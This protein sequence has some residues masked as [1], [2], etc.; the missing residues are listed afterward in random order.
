M[1]ASHRANTFEYRDADLKETKI[2]KT[3]EHTKNA[4]KFVLNFPT[5]LV[6]TAIL[7][8]TKGAVNSVLSVVNPVRFWKTKERRKRK[9]AR[10]R[11]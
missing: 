7:A 1:D 6:R 5:N 2:G 4:V 10:R 9:E 11:K 3:V 8:Q